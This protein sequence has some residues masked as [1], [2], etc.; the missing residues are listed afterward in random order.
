VSSPA[1]RTF[2]Q[3]WLSEHVTLGPRDV[4]TRDDLLVATAEADASYR[5]MCPLLL[6]ATQR[7]TITNELEPSRLP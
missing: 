5:R 3:R 2:A 1:R 6:L 4:R 7:A